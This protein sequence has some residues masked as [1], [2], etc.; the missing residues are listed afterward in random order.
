MYDLVHRP[1]RGDM[2]RAAKSG[3]VFLAL[4]GYYVHV[5]GVKALLDDGFELGCVLSL[6][7]FLG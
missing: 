7:R 4:G 1:H 2:A 3:P 5:P 6:H